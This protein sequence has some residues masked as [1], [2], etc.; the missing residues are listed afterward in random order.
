MFKSISSITSTLHLLKKWKEKVGL[1]RKKLEN[2]LTFKPLAPKI[3]KK[4]IQE[5]IKIYSKNG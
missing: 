3:Y 5:S 1:N 4:I 2:N